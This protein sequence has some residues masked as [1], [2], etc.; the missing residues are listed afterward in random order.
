MRAT[1]IA[2]VCLTVALGGA[3]GCGGDPQADVDRLCEAAVTL[4]PSSG[5]KEL[6]TLEK[7]WARMLGHLSMSTDAGR[8]I[9]T[10]AY[11]ATAGQL[12]EMIRAATVAAGLTWDCEAMARLDGAFRGANARVAPILDEVK[13]LFGERRDPDA[14]VSAISHYLSAHA[15]D[16][17]IDRIAAAMSDDRV[18]PGDA[19]DA[20]AARA[21]GAE[22][23]ALCSEAP[24]KCGAAAQACVTLLTRLAPRNAEGRSMLAT[25]SGFP[26]LLDKAIDIVDDPTLLNARL[27]GV[28]APGVARTRALFEG[29]LK[30]VLSDMP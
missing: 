28:P 9:R 6:A 12:D 17:R 19:D 5:C 2:T 14:V 26:L 21:L 25:A 27:D 1:L 7:R 18:H 24:K 3:L 13:A 20:Q 11:T 10:A 15:K 23:A 4:C 30:P 29:V 22:L 16:P 8:E